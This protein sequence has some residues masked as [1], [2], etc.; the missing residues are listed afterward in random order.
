M[1]NKKY[2]VLKISSI[3]FLVLI[4]ITLICYIIFD[5][6]KDKN[7]NKTN[8]NNNSDTVIEEIPKSDKPEFN[9]NDIVEALNSNSNLTEEEKN[10]IL[11]S[12]TIFEDNYDYYSMNDLK[13]KLSTLKIKYDNNTNA[14][15]DTSA[16]TYDEIK[17]LITFYKVTS[18]DETDKS[19]FTH[20]FSHLMQFLTLNG[21]FCSLL[22]EATNSIANSEYYGK[23]LYYNSSYFVQQN[24][25]RMLSFIIG[26]DSIK[27]FYNYPQIQNIID[28][29]YKIYPNYETANQF[30]DLLNDYQVLYKSK[31]S[32]EELEKKE[33]Q[34][35]DVIKFYYEKKYQS[36]PD[37]D[38]VMLYYIDS[39]EFK[40]KIKS[41][42]NIE[43][44]MAV[45]AIIKNTPSIINTTLNN[46]DYI[47]A[48]E[49]SNIIDYEE[50]PLD[51]AIG[52]GA[53]NSENQILIDGWY[54]KED[55]KTAMRPIT[56]NAEKI[57]FKVND[58]NR[59]INN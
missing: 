2:N 28:E 55:G 5:N 22:V 53:I 19:V 27:K 18:F 24:I 48:I 8:N 49:K 45:T 14:T 50:V 40:N 43:D 12:K 33:Q 16:G 3:I 36:S 26:N 38:L 56:V 10:K 35:K 34:I 6:N 29:L 23:D 44:N 13:H 9:F 42:A 37:K 7:N 17:N 20:E 4:I 30:I 51:Y 46:K 1:N 52:L 15:D 31:D 59:F 21:S 39:I 58:S 47:Y 57:E 41:V 32:L 25:V 54:I 11:E